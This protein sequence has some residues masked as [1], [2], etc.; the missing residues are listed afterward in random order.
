MKTLLKIVGLAVVLLL[1]IVL[2]F[3]GLIVKMTV[4]R[5]GPRMLGVPVKLQEVEL[6]LR[7]GQLI[8][9][10]LHVGNPVGFKAESLFDLRILKIDLDVASLF[11][12]TL[13][14]KEIRIE[15]PEITYERGLRDSNIGALQAQLSP[16]DSAAAP[17]AALPA[18]KDK[19]GGKKVIIKK[20]TIT[21]A[22]VKVTF[23]ALG[24][25]AMPLPLPT[26]TLND[27][28]GGEKD[29]QGVTFVAAI[30]EV[31]NA[32]LS[33]VTKAVTGVA[34]LAVDGFKAGGAGVRKVGG[35][36]GE[37][38]GKTLGGAT[39]LFKKSPEPPPPPPK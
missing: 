2:L 31:L 10:G 23:T 37:G 32:I 20:L 29:K 11:K 12:N 25:Q 19:A 14:I 38:I 13:V 39:S 8:L 30:R 28:G 5:V 22:K 3:S 4:N 33:S 9:R 26:I 15:A 34:G 18:E 24:G 27:I 7:R 6:S 1:I 16:K 36:L 21:G 35:A 17:E